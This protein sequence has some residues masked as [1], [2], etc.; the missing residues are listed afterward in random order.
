MYDNNEMAMV[1]QSM[2][3]EIQMHP[4]DV[5]LSAVE[6]I[7]EKYL[8]LKIKYLA[9]AIEMEKLEGE[10]EECDNLDEK[11]LDCIEYK[12]KMFNLISDHVDALAPF[13]QEGPVMPEGMEDDMEMD[14][15]L[16]D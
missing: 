9:K 5:I 8:K 6:E 3:M 16:V 11:I 12:N 14:E 7:L 15:E 1:D 2:E 10:D 4:A 13:E